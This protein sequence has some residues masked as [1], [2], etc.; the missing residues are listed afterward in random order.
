MKIEPKV[1]FPAGS[2]W[3]RK[4]GEVNFEAELCEQL[5]LERALRSLPEELAAWLPSF[6]AVSQ[7][8]TQEEAAR[9]LGVSRGTML[10]HHRQLRA[11]L[12]NDLG[13]A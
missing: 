5:D 6:Q 12:Q 10:Y 11:Y 8:V 13:I 3:L 2:S 1:V 4:I 9:Q 7:G